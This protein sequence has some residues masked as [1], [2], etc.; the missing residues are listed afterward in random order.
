MEKITKILIIILILINLIGL[1]LYFNDFKT[2]EN[3]IIENPYNDEEMKEEIKN[4]NTK[5]NDLTIKINEFENQNITEIEV[6]EIIK[7]IEVTEVT[8][9][10]EIEIEKNGIKVIKQTI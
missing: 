5:I 10:E 4:L 9:I 1:S 6:K 2:I 7:I 8:E 3:K